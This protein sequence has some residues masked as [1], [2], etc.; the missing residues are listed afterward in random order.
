MLNI[1]TFE[2]SL[3]YLVIY[4]GLVVFFQDEKKLEDT[5]PTYK[6]RRKVCSYLEEVVITIKLQFRKDI[7]SAPKS[8][9]AKYHLYHFHCYSWQATNFSSQSASC[10]GEGREVKKNKVRSM[11]S[12]LLSKFEESNPSFTLRRQV[13]TTKICPPFPLLRTLSVLDSVLH[14]LYSTVV[15]YSTWHVCC[16]MLYTTVC[17]RTEAS[18]Q[19][20]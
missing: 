6:R 19:T 18:L 10:V 3:K 1:F 12:Q 2:W 9:T 14:S 4:Y 16:Q 13:R 8:N 11:A 7:L 17:Y 15:W 20:P 5:D